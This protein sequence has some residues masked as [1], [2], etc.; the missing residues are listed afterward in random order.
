[1]EYGGEVVR[2]YFVEGLSGE[3][4][5]LAHALTDLGASPRRAEPHVLV[6]MVD[7]ANVSGRIF[8]LSRPDGTRVAVASTPQ[9][10]VTFPSARPLALCEGPGRDRSSLPS[11]EP[12][13]LPGAGTA[14]AA[15]MHRP[16]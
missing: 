16:P 6:N 13:A 3:Q 1:M 15:V 4:Y 11:Y 2:G 8:A 7:P 10:W 9:A 14:L 12:G 5:A